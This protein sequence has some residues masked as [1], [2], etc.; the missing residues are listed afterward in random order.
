MLTV[1]KIVA[2]KGN[3]IVN[4]KLIANEKFVVSEGY[5]IPTEKINKAIYDCIERAK[6]IFKKN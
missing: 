4:Q 2:C 1:R 3:V 5:A 6:F